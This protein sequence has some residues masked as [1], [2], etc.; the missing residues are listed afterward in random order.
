M[1]SSVVNF[2]VPMRSAPS[3]SASDTPIARSTC[4]GVW[5]PEEQAAPVERAT[6]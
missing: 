3:C 6:L 5:A 1:S 2:P 4:E